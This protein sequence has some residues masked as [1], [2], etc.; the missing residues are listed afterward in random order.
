MAKTHRVTPSLSTAPSAAKVVS[1]QQ[2]SAPAGHAPPTARSIAT[3]LHSLV[4]DGTPPSPATISSMLA[5]AGNELRR[6]TGIGMAGV[7][8]TTAVPVTG[9]NL[10]TNPGG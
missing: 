2:L 4:G 10:L 5:Y 8:T 1:A 7:V 3:A 9:P 6:I